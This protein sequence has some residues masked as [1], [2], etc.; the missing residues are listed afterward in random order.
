MVSIQQ[1]NRY[2]EHKCFIQNEPR[3]PMDGDFSAANYNV[4]SILSPTEARTHATLVKMFQ[5]RRSHFVAVF[6]DLGHSCSF[7]FV[8]LRLFVF[9]CF[10]VFPF[11]H[12]LL[13]VFAP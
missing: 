11:F 7:V 2:P 4:I 10:L 5:V 8:D 6:V 12:H 1:I 13:G 3:H 9:V